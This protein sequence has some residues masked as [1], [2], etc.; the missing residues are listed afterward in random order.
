MNQLL[1]TIATE[2]LV[3]AT[4]GMN[5][6]GFATST[7][8]QDRRTPAQIAEDTT[9]MRKLTPQSTPQTTPTSY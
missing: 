9:W 7:H 1:E 6:T 4:G 5:T 2:T 3:T 8:I